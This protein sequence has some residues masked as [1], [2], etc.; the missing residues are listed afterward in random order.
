MKRLIPIILLLLIS[1][2]CYAGMNILQFAGATPAAVATYACT[3]ATH[4]SANNAIVCCEDM[5]GSTNCITGSLPYCR[6]TWTP[7]GTPTFNAA[8]MD[9]TYSLNINNTS[10]AQAISKTVTTSGSYYT[11]Y[12]VRIEEIPASSN[13]VLSAFMSSGT[14][15]GFV[16]LTT[17]GKFIVYSG[18]QNATTVNGVTKGSTY[19]VWHGYTKESSEGAN[20]GTAY[21]CFSTTTT[22]GTG[23]NCATVTTG[24]EVSTIT[25]VRF[26]AASI[27][28]VNLTYDRIR[29]NTSDFGNDPK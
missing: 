5:E 23:D 12:K 17:T 24:D 27:N 20:D 29:V 6:N 19:Y 1:V 11:F 9:G 7:T 14:A 15:K 18:T 21:V 13:K 26:G 22:K 28:Q 2:P 25:T 10:E 3:D 8:G 4:D 16:S